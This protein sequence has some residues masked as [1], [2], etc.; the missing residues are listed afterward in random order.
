MLYGAAYQQGASVKS[1]SK[2]PCIHGCDINVYVLIGI[3]QSSTS[4]CVAQLGTIWQCLALLCG[5]YTKR[6]W[7]V[8]SSA[9][10][11]PA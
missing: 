4:S 3:I 1:V 5:P 6:H 2:F 8:A 7:N 11:Y 9:L 10:T